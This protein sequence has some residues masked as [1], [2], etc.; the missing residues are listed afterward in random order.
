MLTP[1]ILCIPPQIGGGTLP[2]DGQSEVLLAERLPGGQRALTFQQPLS[3]AQA[4][5]LTGAGKVL[6]GFACLLL[7][8]SPSS[9]GN[10]NLPGPYW[11]AHASRHYDSPTLQ[12]PPQ[13]LPCPSAREAPAT[14]PAPTCWAAPPLPPPLA[15]CSS[16]RCTWWCARGCRWR[17]TPLWSA[18][19]R[20]CQVGVHAACMARAHSSRRAVPAWLDVYPPVPTHP[21]P[22][23]LQARCR[24]VRCRPAWSM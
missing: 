23:L 10:V 5:Q 12:V 9:P 15:A 2:D 7:A 13:L 24:P 4:A 16:R 17:P 20:C 8:F 14:P 18:C 19:M 11:W 21:W 6:Q 3:A 22:G 1:A